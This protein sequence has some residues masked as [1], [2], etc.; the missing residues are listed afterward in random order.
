MYIHSVV[1]PSPPFIS[2]TV[3]HLSKWKLC[4]IK[5]L[6][7]ISPTPQ[8][9]TTTNLLFYEIDYYRSLIWGFPVGSSSKEFAWNV[10]D[11]RDVGLISGSGRSPGGGHDNPFQYSFWQ[12]SINRETWWDIVHG[13]GK[14]WTWLKQLST[15]T[16]G[17]HISGIIWYSSF[18]D[19]LNSLS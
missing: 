3:F 9:I 11:T 1:H 2:K 12:N 18:V 10:G 14:S 4:P 16:K 5:Q 15:H 7:S 13:V 19:W 6:I 17:S 8:L